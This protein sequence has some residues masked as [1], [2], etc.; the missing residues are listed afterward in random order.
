MNIETM[1]SWFDYNIQFP[2]NSIN[3]GSGLYKL[4]LI[5]VISYIIATIIGMFKI[6][7]NYSI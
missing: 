1:K 2:L 4:I 3:I 7:I 5:I 6:H